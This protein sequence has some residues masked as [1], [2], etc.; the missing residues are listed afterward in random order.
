MAGTAP[1]S[2]DPG[3]V[4]V[5]PAARGVADRQVEREFERVDVLSPDRYL[6]AFGEGVAAVEVRTGKTGSDSV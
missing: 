1:I 6:P 3:V 5:L 2:V 4:G